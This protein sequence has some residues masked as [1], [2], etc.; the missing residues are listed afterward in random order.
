MKNYWKTTLK[1][2]VLWRNLKSEL[3][4]NL[5]EETDSVTIIFSKS[6]PN[7]GVTIKST[8]LIKLIKSNTLLTCEKKD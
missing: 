3:A 7:F 2:Y 8:K 4:N 6:L 5:I 1:D